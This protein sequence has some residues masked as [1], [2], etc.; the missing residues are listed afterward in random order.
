MESAKSSDTSIIWSPKYKYMILYFIGWLTFG[1]YWVYDTPGA[2]QTQLTEWFGGNTSYTAFMNETLYYVY[3]FPNIVLAFFGGYIVDKVTGI[4]AGA[5]LFCGLIV[6]GDIIFAMGIQFK[7]YW[8]CVVGRFIFGLGGESLT[9]A[10]NAYT[11]RWFSG[12]EMS[13]AFGLV[14]AFSRIGTSINFLITPYFAENGVPFAIWF[15]A[16][17]C[18]ISMCASLYCALLDWYGD[19]A[20]KYLR[21]K[22]G[23]NSE[24]DVQCSHVLKF[25]RM[26]W[27]V[28][29]NCM[30]FY[31]A[32]FTFYTFASQFFQETGPSPR[33]SPTE[34]SNYVAI[35][36]LIA[37]VVCPLMGWLLDK[38]GRVMIWLTVATVILGVVLL[39]CLGRSFGTAYPDSGWAAFGR[40]P[41]PVIMVLCGFAYSIFAS[42]IWPL[43][44]FIIKRDMLGTGFG[45]M[46]SVQNFALMLIPFLVGLIQ[47]DGTLLAKKG[48]IYV[49]SFLFLIGILAL[50]FVS[51]IVIYIWDKIST[52]GI[53]NDTGEKKEKYQDLLN[54]VSKPAL[55][56]NPS[57]EGLLSN[58]DSIQ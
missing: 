28:F 49:V 9:V 10:Q 39:M 25:P 33:P 51:T 19:D 57:E 17:M 11:A 3:N 8:L 44:P 5:M 32:I 50:S 15:G 42:G 6:S 12:K 23:D 34:A 38:Y 52:G 40:I 35:P 1:S 21:S 16:E 20:A 14:V 22:G 2:I 4:R 29:L 13:F 46:T 37:I 18:L 7:I 48:Y 31:S 26:A 43:L 58:N 56:V 55:S 30:L 47:S 41:I 45:M 24:P 54:G 36:N 27:L 53:L